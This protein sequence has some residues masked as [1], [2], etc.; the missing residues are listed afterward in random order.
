MPRPTNALQRS[1][2]GNSCEAAKQAASLWLSDFNYH[3]PIARHSIRVR[4]VDSLFIARLTY[5]EASTAI[6][7]HEPLAEETPIQLNKSR[8][9]AMPS[10]LT[11][12]RRTMS[13]FGL[14]CREVFDGLRLRLKPDPARRRGARSLLRFRCRHAVDGLPRRRKPVS[15]A[16]RLRPQEDC[17]D[18]VK[19]IFDFNAVL[20]APLGAGNDGGFRSQQR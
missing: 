17:G 19:G 10:A 5:S 7:P 11:R 9:E 1:F 4:R 12:C 6:E 18:L 15:A 3:G 16:S 20:L 13:R 8:R 2:F 14:K